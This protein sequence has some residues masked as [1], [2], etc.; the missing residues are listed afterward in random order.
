MN[1]GPTG[2]P[3]RLRA[4]LPLLRDMTI[5]HKELDYRALRDKICPSTVSLAR[6]GLPTCRKP[7]LTRAILIQLQKKEFSP[8][9]KV[10]LLVGRIDQVI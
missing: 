7:G 1:K 9:E 5:R 3:K 6:A 8:E 10:L 4:V 2:T